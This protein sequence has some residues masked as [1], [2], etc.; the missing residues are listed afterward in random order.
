MFR[1]GSRMLA[2][3][4]HRW[5]TH[6]ATPEAHFFP[7]RLGPQDV[8]HLMREGAGSRGIRAMLNYRHWVVPVDASGHLVPLPDVRQAGDECL[9]LFSEAASYD[10]WRLWVDMRRQADGGSQPADGLT[11]RSMSGLEFIWAMRT[12]MEDAACAAILVDLQ[13]WLARSSFRTAVAWHN[14]LFVEAALTSLSMGATPNVLPETAQYLTLGLAT[15]DKYLAVYTDPPSLLEYQ[16]E[17]VRAEGGQPLPILSLTGKALVDHVESEALR[18]VVFN[19]G[20]PIQVLMEK[21]ELQ[22]IPG[23]ADATVDDSLQSHQL[24]SVEAPLLGSNPKP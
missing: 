12:H 11:P 20:T 9:F 15:D 13:R 17:M 21:E 19:P 5:L 2:G 1:K 14:N 16:A 8:Q 7:D 22:G 3:P 18:G 6:T 4:V 10:T 23:H 24:T